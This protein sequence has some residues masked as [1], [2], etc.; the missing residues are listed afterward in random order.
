MMDVTMDYDSIAKH[1]SMLGAGSEQAKQEQ[2]ERIQQHYD[3]KDAQRYARLER[4][5]SNYRRAMSA[6]LE[7]RGYTVR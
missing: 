7:G 4:Q 5:A 3:S 6:C 2:A 1:G